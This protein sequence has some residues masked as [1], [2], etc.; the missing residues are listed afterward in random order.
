MAR[1]ASTGGT[2]QDMLLG[3]L[4][5]ELTR[6]HAAA[7]P[8]GVVCCSVRYETD[9]V[10]EEL[11][12]AHTGSRV[13]AWAVEMVVDTLV[14]VESFQIRAGVRSVQIVHTSVGTVQ[15][16]V[17]PLPPKSALLALR[18]R[19]TLPMGWE[20]AGRRSPGQVGQRA[21]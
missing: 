4:M 20:R 9:V 21:T 10:V 13:E 16:T 14:E 2:A 3:K 12:L 1:K 5:A 11:V 18:G 7:F 8:Q 6:I 15:H 17:C 19:R